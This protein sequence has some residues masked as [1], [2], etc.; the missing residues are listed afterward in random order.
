M[1]KKTV[2]LLRHAEPIHL[3][4]EKYYLGQSDL[5]LSPKGKQQAQLLSDFFSTIKFSAI[6]SSDLQRAVQTALPIAQKHRCSLRIIK[7]LREINLGRWEGLRR[8]EVKAL[9]PGE[10][11]LRGLNLASY[12]PPEGESLA[13]LQKRVVPVYREI[14][15]NCDGDIVIVSHAGV[16]RVIL[17]NLLGIPLDMLFTIK[18]EYACVNVINYLDKKGSNFQYE[19]LQQPFKGSDRRQESCH[20]DFHDQGYPSKA[21]D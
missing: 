13:D 14:V 9:Y 19:Y 4:R 16:N 17:C 3:F 11:E 7:E 18:Q 2:Y 21:K 8:A 12:R 10:F 15:D 20:G 6:F 5:P 1:K